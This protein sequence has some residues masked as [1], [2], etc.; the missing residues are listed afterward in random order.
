MDSQPC[1]VPRRIGIVHKQSSP[2]AAS[3]AQTAA[4]YL[5]GRDVE[6]L[7]DEEDAGNPNAAVALYREALQIYP[8]YER[9]QVLLASLSAKGREP[10]R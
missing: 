5:R 2:A 1:P 6:V 7:L 8:E 4:Q 3:C 9:A 10:S